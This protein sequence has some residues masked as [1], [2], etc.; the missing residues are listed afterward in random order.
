LKIALLKIQNLF[1]AHGLQV[2]SSCLKEAGH[3][4]K[5]LFLAMSFDTSLEQSKI[6]SVL[7]ETSDVDLVG[8]SVMSNDIP[9]VRRLTSRLKNEARKPVIWGGTHPTVM[10]EECVNDADYIFR[11]EAEVS[12][13]RFVDCLERGEDPSAAG[14]PGLCTSRDSGAARETPPA[15]RVEDLDSLPLPDIDL[16]TQFYTPIHEPDFRQLTPEVFRE[17]A[18]PKGSYG[19]MATRGCPCGCSY[20]INSFLKALYKGLPRIRYR[21]VD[22]VIEELELAKAHLGVQ[23]IRVDDDAFMSMP[24]EKIRKFAALYKERIGLPLYNFGAS[25]LDVDEEK[26]EILLDAGM[27][28]MRLG[29]QSASESTRRMYRRPGSVQQMREAVSVLERFKSRMEPVSYDVITDNPWEPDLEYVRTLRFLVRLPKPFRLFIYSLTFFPGTPLFDKAR[30]EGL[31]SDI[32]RDV[33]DKYMG[34]IKDTYL[35]ELL[36]LLRD[37]AREARPFPPFVMDLL[38]S[39]LLVNTTLGRKFST[40]LKLVIRLIRRLVRVDRSRDLA[41]GTILRT[42]TG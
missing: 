23:S 29:L 40:L 16:T 10:P 32:E 17:S 38:T 2:L 42:R 33:Y 6:D 20:C 37:L 39:R 15:P 30:E 3:Q 31:I 21:S 26:M 28:Y 19:L 41:G 14:I 25:L 12:L 13:L 4:V 1:Q 9:I 35:N 34:F 11:G 7:N 24:I 5:L 22:R 36:F 8:I 18:A 27:V